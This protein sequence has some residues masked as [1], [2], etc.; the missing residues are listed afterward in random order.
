MRQRA[1]PVTIHPREPRGVILT[2]AAGGFAAAMMLSATVAAQAQDDSAKRILKAMSDYVTSQKNI[3]I[4]YD[5]DIEVITLELQKLQFTNS[6]QLVLSRPDTLRA[7]RTGGYTD[8]E[9][10][11][12][13]KTFTVNDR[14]NKV[15]AQAEGVAT[16]DQVVARLRNEYFVEAPGADLLLTN[17]YDVL[18]DNVVDAK[19]IGQGVIDGV[20]CEHLAFRSHET[21]WQIWI[22]AGPNP[23]PR[24]YVI[25][26]KGITGAP[27]YT[28]RVKE[29]RT[30]PQIAAD[31]F[32][33]KAAAG[34]QK[35]DFKA[36][37]LIDEVPPGV[38]VGEKQ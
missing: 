4:T 5:S 24:K 23:I 8:V 34:T 15:Y 19:H 13:G 36:L 18:M 33:F 1:R 29:W 35:V 37:A 21:D 28:L 7:S 16:V 27:Q 3:S 38:V 17:P 12:D 32:S 20:E 25:T 26:S 31:T 22:Q 2:I 9:F 11:F 10:L 14:D 6:G 30:D